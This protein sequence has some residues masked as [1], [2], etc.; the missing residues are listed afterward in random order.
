MEKKILEAKVA[1]F[2]RWHYAFDLGGIST[3]RPGQTKVNR[4]L[5]RKK[6]FFDPLVQMLGGSLRGKT[7][8]DL[9][10]N[11]GFWSLLAI[12]AGCDKVVGI[13]GRSMHVEQANLVFEVKGVPRSR[14]EF[15]EADVFSMDWKALGQFD[16]VLCLGLLY[17]VNRP[18]ELLESLRSVNRELAVIDTALSAQEAPVFD[19]ALEPTD[20][21][22]NALHSALV[23]IPSESALRLVLA[24]L[25][26]EV[27]ECPIR[28]DD[29]G[30]CED[31][32][33]GRRKAFVCRRG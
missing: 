12:E 20:D 10:C 22:R 7:V 31:Y 21:P 33:T 15:L 8:L 11:A 14:Y 4:H 16:I 30:G 17:H 26:Y 27:S 29:F 3:F 6:L 32:Q 18:V 5:Q 19:V 13:E 2:A 25:G 1:S 28:F 24:Q 9:G 23:L